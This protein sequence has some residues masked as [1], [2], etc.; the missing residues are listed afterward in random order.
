M[1]C[2]PVCEAGELLY[3]NGMKTMKK[4]KTKTRSWYVK[5]LDDVFSQYIRL[6]NADFAGYAT[7]VTCGVS[8]PWKEQQ[9]GHYESRGKYGTRWDEKN[10]NVQCYRCNVALKGN[11]PAYARYLIR[12]Y[13]ATIL[14]EL[15]MKA[16]KS[17][18]YSIGELQLLIDEYTKRVNDLT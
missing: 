18:M 6:R 7:C 15:E 9:C 17:P 14:D 11:Y 8:K 10:C 4:V 12:K 1:F 2:S 13:G 16:S 5:R 3:N